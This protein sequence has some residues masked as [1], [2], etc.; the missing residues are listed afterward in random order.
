MT[1]ANAERVSSAFYT[2]PLPIRKRIEKV[3]IIGNQ[4]PGLFACDATLVLSIVKQELKALRIVILDRICD[5]PSSMYGINMTS[6][7]VD[8]EVRVSSSGRI[9]GACRRDTHSSGA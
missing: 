8:A 9:L 2:I 4:N 5:T 6:I 7:P 1:T 3:R